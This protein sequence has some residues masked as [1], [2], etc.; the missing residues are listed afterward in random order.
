MF[1]RRTKTR[2][3]VVSY[4]R[5]LFKLR[6]ETDKPNTW[7]L[8]L[9]GRKLAVVRS[10]DVG[11]TDSVI[12][13]RFLAYNEVPSWSCLYSVVNKRWDELVKADIESPKVTTRGAL[14]PISH[15]VSPHSK[16]ECGNSIVT[17]F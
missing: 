17:G 7:A 1:T 2:F 13:H 8:V 16:V 12:M 4:L 14:M 6:P 9:R 15:C 11:L 5:C 10:F 3:Q